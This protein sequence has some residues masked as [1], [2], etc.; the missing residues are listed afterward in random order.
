MKI[1]L[2]NTEKNFWLVIRLSCLFNFSKNIDLKL[3]FTLCLDLFIIM[4]K[5]HLMKKT[6]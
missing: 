3:L 6:G 1:Y 2:M 4:E 5:K